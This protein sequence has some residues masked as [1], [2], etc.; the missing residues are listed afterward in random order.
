MT[1]SSRHRATK[2]ASMCLL[3]GLA[4]LAAVSVALAHK[5]GVHGSASNNLTQEA[6]D[7][8]G[9]VFDSDDE[10]LIT[11]G[12]VDEDE[13]GWR[14][15]R[16]HHYNPHTLEGSHAFG[17]EWDNAL[18]TSRAR[19]TL[20]EDAFAN[21]SVR[22]NGDETREAQGSMHALGRVLHLLQD[23]ASP[24]HVH[25]PDG[26]GWFP[27]GEYYSD[28]EETWSPSSS[29]YADWPWPAVSG[30]PLTPDGAT[31]PH[32][33]RHDWN[34]ELD[35]RSWY[36]MCGKLIDIPVSERSEIEGYM[37]AMAW[38]TYFHT[39]FY[40]QINENEHNPAPARSSS[41]RTNILRRMFPNRIAFHN[42]DWG[43]DYWTIEEVGSYDRRSQYFPEDWWPCPGPYPE[44]SE[45]TTGGSSGIKGRFYIYLHYYEGSSSEP[46][47][48]ATPPD[49]WP[50]DSDNGTKSLA[51]YYGEVLLPL[52][53][54]FGAGLLRELFPAPS[55]L[56]YPS[57]SYDG[58]YTVSWPECSTDAG[59]AASYRLERSSDGGASW[60]EVY[61]GQSTSY[62]ENVASGHYRYR[63]RARWFSNLP[64]QGP[65]RIG[66]HECVVDQSGSEFESTPVADSFISLSDPDNNFG[67]VNMMFVAGGS[68]AIG[69]RHSLARFDLT[70]IPRGSTVHSVEL[71]L[72]VANYFGDSN[73][74]TL[75]DLGETSWREHE[76]TA[77][78]LYIRDRENIC[79]TDMGRRDE[80]TWTSGDYPKL[81][82]VGVN[83][84][85]S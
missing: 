22:W 63:V 13:K 38:I 85:L 69:W 15:Y 84:I 61:S 6:V 40:G 11:Q 56:S 43:D 17:I 73:N 71:T 67:S 37:K 58:E 72:S 68:S 46:E 53:A 78:N 42:S 62:R 2:C 54:R 34:S 26:H 76:V 9:I 44:G 45:D 14:R 39:S 83:P 47:N 32:A 19:W 24:P 55:S 5:P 81:L 51:Q 65:A 4:V 66:R 79:T 35:Y 31:I 1:T 52:A 64:I 48:R 12:A 30:G 20:M 23:M 41:G 10:D 7:I 49:K 27:H 77:N 74:V 50:D 8:C 80:W 57:T 70:D 60:T 3:I 25:A 18:I 33:D 28:F 29:E 16:H 36:E 75:A 59:P 82:A 21:P